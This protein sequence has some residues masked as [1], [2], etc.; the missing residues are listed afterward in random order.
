MKNETIYGGK[1]TCPYGSLL[2]FYHY[3]VNRHPVSK[4]NTNVEEATFFLS[5]A[6]KFLLFW[7]SCWQFRV[8][9]GS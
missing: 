7:G 6:V 9:I 4:V 8:S 3:A 1:E 5:L 2:N